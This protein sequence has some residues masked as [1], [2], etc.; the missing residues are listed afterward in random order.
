M[1]TITRGDIVKVSTD[2]GFAGQK[3]RTENAVFVC[4]SG[5]CAIVTFCENNVGARNTRVYRDRI[6]V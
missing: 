3:G 6:S 2:F 5:D 1:D 4:W